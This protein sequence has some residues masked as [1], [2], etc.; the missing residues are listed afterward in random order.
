[1]VSL[2]ADSVFLL[3]GPSP[4]IFGVRDWLI[5][6]GADPHKIHYEL[7]S[8]PG[9][10]NQI[11]QA[12]GPDAE[13]IDQKKSSVTIRLDGLSHDFQLPYK[14]DTILNAAIKQGADLPYAC[15]A[16]VCATCRAKLLKGKVIMD[17]N[18]ALAEEE[19]EDGFILTCQSHP[20]SPELLIDFDSR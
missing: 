19:L 3:C 14:G 17:Q 8:D 2:T 15:K 16:G 13:I 12:S 5:Q 1:M 6:Q 20:D 11:S 18:Y 4:M 7:F 9:E 10:K